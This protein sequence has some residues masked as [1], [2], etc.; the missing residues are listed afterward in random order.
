MKHAINAD[1][2]ADLAAR[3]RSVEPSADLA[4]LEACIPA[5]DALEMK[6]R[7]NLVADAIAAALPGDSCT[8]LAVIAAVAAQGEFADFAAWPLC[9]FI[10]R[11]ALD[12]PEAALTAMA[13][14]TEA[15]SCEFAIRPYLTNHF[16]LA[17]EH[18]RSWTTSPSEHVRRLASEGTRPR[19][20]WGPNVPQ[21]SADASHGLGVLESLRH[22]SSETVR[23]SVAN[24]LNDI[25]K[26]DPEMVISTLRRWADEPATN[27]AMVRHALRSLVKA[28]DAGAMEVLGFTTNPNIDVAHFTVAPNELSLG[29][30]L[31]LTATITSLAAVDQ[32]VVV[33]FVVH[34]VLAN[35]D[36]SPK[37]F[38]WSTPTIGA[39]E[40][41][42]LTKKRRIATASTRRYYA[43]HHVVALQVAGTVRAESGFT[44]RE[45][46]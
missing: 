28:G 32:H 39:H 24:H 22:D 45:G 29:T 37:V 19:L 31:E 11:H 34:H 30:S 2:V 15:F 9:S 38:K 26:T 18:V 8:K 43:G 36:T 23:R 1:L 16:E 10:E 33:D 40:T 12:N 4:Q 21:I 27:M 6:D 7:I 20:P 46:S 35:G 42:I 17:M 14:V 25:A 3:I 13:T 44:L 41:I 5:L